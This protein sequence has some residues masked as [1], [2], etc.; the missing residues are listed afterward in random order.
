MFRNLLGRGRRELIG[1]HVAV[2]EP[3]PEVTV[4]LPE[5]EPLL[6]VVQG[7]TILGDE[8]FELEE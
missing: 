2:L 5:P 4:S 6:A 1:S 8:Y 3:A 7:G